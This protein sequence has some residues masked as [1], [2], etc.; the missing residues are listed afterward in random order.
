MK[1]TEVQTKTICMKSS[2]ASLNSSST[3]DCK[4][5]VVD[6]RSI[7]REL[8]ASRQ[9]ADRLE[10]QLRALSRMHLAAITGTTPMEAVKWNFGS[11]EAEERCLER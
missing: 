11:K 8:K 4:S 7:Q 1:S 6:S 3:E 5:E 10:A 9:R 2:V